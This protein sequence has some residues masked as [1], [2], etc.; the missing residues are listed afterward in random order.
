MKGS[1]QLAKELIERIYTTDTLKRIS[2][3]LEKLS[4]NKGFKSHTN[5]IINDDS[6]TDSQKKNQLLYIIRS[7]EISTLFDFFSDQLADYSFWIFSS[8]QIDYFDKFVQAFQKATQDV[9]VIYLTT[10][11][12][13]SPEDLKAISNNLGKSFGYKVVI[14]HDI[15]TGILGGAQIRIENLIFDYSLRSKFRHFQKEWL[16]SISDTEKSIGF[17]TDL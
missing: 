7:V 14:N 16:K 15:N 10:A 3:A 11:V 4:Q 8:G 9:G 2:N 5:D 12:E 1:E 6:L 17:H 13:I